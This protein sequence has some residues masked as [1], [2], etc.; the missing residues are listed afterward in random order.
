M[1]ATIA[2]LA[3]TTLS[4]APMQDAQEILS[5]ARAKKAARMAD[6]QNYTIIQRVQGAMESPLYY[7]AFTTPGGSETLYRLVP[8]QEWQERGAPPGF[9]G[10]AMAEGMK[11]GITY[12][13]NHLSMQMAGS[14]AAGLVGSEELTGMLAGAN[15]FL[16]A[17]ATPPPNTSFNDAMKENVDAGMFAAQAQFVGMQS[18]WERNAFL[19]RAAAPPD[20]PA[21][22]VGEATFAL[23]RASMWIDA[24]NYVQLRLR[25]EGQMKAGKKSV[26]IVIELEERDYVFVNGLFEPRKKT[27]RITGL[28]G[29]MELDP[30][31]AKKVAKMR[32]DMEKLKA[33][34]AA[35]PPSQKAMIQ[36]QLDKAQAM[37]DQMTGN[38]VIE[39]DVEFMIYS[40]NKGPPF[41]WM[42]FCPSLELNVP[43]FPP[44]A[45]GSQVPTDA[46]YPGPPPPQQP[47]CPA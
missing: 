47:Q 13:A 23:E 8:M 33:Q 41:K 17:A 42:P 3:A 35:M 43:P 40:V 31:E 38:D 37:M 6:V 18:V 44:L 1:I 10:Q 22:Q 32:A 21:Q 2:L 12:A 5:T 14:P 9:D 28:M 39:T 7:E 4:T 19:L 46:N 30:K 16:D 36:G 20:L 27:M 45:Q 34:I 11:L 24:D 25:M 26:P 15:A 29:G